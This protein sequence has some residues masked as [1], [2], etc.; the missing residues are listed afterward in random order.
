MI[1]RPPRSTLFPY[2]TLFRSVGAG[3]LTRS[4]LSLQKVS[5]GYDPKGILTA[6][7]GLS[8]VKYP[9]LRD[10]SAFYERLLDELGDGPGVA[11]A[12][13]VSKLPVTGFATSTLTVQGGPVAP[14][15]EPHAHYRFISPG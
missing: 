9:E 7:V 1:R 12:R 13:V 2:T 8:P 4:F 6:G 14:G 15:H 10:P 3:L 11:S 5:P